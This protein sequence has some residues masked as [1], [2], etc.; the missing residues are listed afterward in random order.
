MR[1]TRKQQQQQRNKRQETMKSAN[2]HQMRFLKKRSSKIVKLY[3]GSCESCRE[4]IL[5]NPGR[6]FEDYCDECQ[7][8]FRGL[9]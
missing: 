9:I 3:N 8:K 2:K 4:L 7:R 1:P 6:P 5:A